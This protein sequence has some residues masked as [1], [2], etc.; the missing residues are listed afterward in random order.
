[1][2]PFP[3]VIEA[4]VPHRSIIRWSWR[5]GWE[6]R[7]CTFKGEVR[8]YRQ[9]F[10][11]AGCHIPIHDSIAP[12][13]DMISSLNFEGHDSNRPVVYTIQIRNRFPNSKFQFYRERG[14][15]A[16]ILFLRPPPFSRFVFLNSF[17]ILPNRWRWCR[18][19][20]MPIWSHNLLVI[21]WVR[22]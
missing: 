14:S 18:L 13:T 1:M 17:L 16:K 10:T 3:E 4:P 6:R 12:N 19:S 2:I 15:R 5:G 8:R 20:L 11:P 22:S 7:W 21:K 9:W